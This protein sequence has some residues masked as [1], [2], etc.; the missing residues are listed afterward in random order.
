MSPVPSLI[1]C[2]NITYSTSY[3]DVAQPL[4]IPKYAHS[5]YDTFTC[6][7]YVPA[8]GDLNLFSSFTVGAHFGNSIIFNFLASSTSELSLVP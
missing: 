3:K 6:S 8:F 7:P 4:N 1:I 2:M 5:P